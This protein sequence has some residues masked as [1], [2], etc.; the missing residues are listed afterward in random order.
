[1]TRHPSY[2]LALMSLLAIVACNDVIDDVDRDVTVCVRA[3]WQDGLASRA[4]SARSHSKAASASRALTATDLFTDVAGDIVVNTADY[5]AIIAVRC[6]DGTDLTLTKGAACG[7]HATFWKYAPSVIYKDKQIERDDLTF[8]ATAEIDG[9]GDLATTADGDRLTGTATKD[10]LH[11]LHLQFTLHHTK[12]LLRFAFKVSD[13]YDK[14]RKIVL[15]SVVCNGTACSLRGSHVL[16]TPTGYLFYAYA[17]IDPAVVTTAYTNIL[18]CTY[19]IYDKDA[20]FTPDAHGIVPTTD[21]TANASHLTR[22]TVTAQN[23]FKLDKIVFSSSAAEDHKI[24]PGYYYDLKVTLDPDY[25]YVLS[26]H[27]NKH[28]TIE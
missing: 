17:Y 28:I 15:N 22:K 6:S 16:L 21:L 18:R 5:P 20:A 14:V 11:D 8:T 4:A 24:K 19:S 26:E 9:D 23:T 3:V 25:L 27:D 7:T 2:I 12:A 13:S 1:M 10:D